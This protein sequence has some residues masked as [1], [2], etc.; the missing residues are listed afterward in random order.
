MSEQEIRELLLKCGALEEDAVTEKGDA[1]RLR[2]RV[3]MSRLYQ[4]PEQVRQLMDVFAQRYAGQR[5]DVVAGVDEEAII[6][7][8]ELASRLQ[9]QCVYMMHRNGALSMR[10]ELTVSPGQRVLILRDVTL[11]GRYTREAVELLRA[12]GATIAGIAS[13]VDLSGGTARF[14]FPFTALLTLDAGRPRVR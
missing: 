5:I 14:R 9:A 7:A 12:M 2:C 1:N 11:T 6:P 13:M 4:H 3:E 8:Y 10:R